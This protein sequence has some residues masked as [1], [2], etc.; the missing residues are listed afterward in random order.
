MRQIK[1]VWPM[2]ERNRLGVIIFIIS[3]ANFF[4]MLILAYVYFHGESSL[5]AHRYLEPAKTGINTLILLSSS[6][7]VW[8][9]ERELKRGG[10][11]RF[12]A[13]LLFTIILGVAFLFGQGV[14]WS[15]LID[16]NVTI[17]SGLFGTTFFTL[18]GFHGFHVFV[19]LVALGIL[20]GLALAGDFKGGKSSA[21][22]VISLYW[23]FVDVVWI[24]IFSIV[25]LGVYI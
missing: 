6:L 3:E 24:V 14:E 11:R 5:T 12:C 7:T 10:Y 1:E 2:V 22:G 23:H 16:K 25:Y 18:T 21:V 17:S 4:L 13:W 8:L 19:G 20:F 15:G 9:A